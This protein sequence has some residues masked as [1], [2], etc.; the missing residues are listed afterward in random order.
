MKKL[1]IVW[2][3]GLMLMCSEVLAKRRRS[4]SSAVLPPE[5]AGWIVVGLLVIGVIALLVTFADFLSALLNIFWMGALVWMLGQLHVDAAWCAYAEVLA[6]ERLSE[7]CVA[8]DGSPRGDFW[9][10]GAYIGFGLLDATLL[11]TMIWFAGRGIRR[12]SQA[13]QERREWIEKGL[14]AKLPLVSQVALQAHVADAMA[15]VKAMRRQWKRPV[16]AH[17][18]ASVVELKLALIGRSQAVGR[19]LTQD[20]VRAILNERRI[21]QA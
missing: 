4:G 3:V 12:R 21:S 5:V 1:D 8:D 6:P 19:A 9:R 13:E 15:L 10:Y 18:V 7:L 20:E 2:F 16:T 14:R 11:G 17:E